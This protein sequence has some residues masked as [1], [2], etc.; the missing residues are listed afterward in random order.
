MILLVLEGQLDPRAVDE[1]ATPP[2]CM[3]CLRTSATRRSLGDAQPGPQFGCAGWL[4]L[5]VANCSFVV[6]GG[7]WLVVF[8]GVVGGCCFGWGLVGSRVVGLVRV[9]VVW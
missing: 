1:L 5:C 6:A 4:G 8:V 9:V 7:V 3:A 2:T